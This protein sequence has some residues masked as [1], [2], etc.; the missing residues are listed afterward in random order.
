MNFFQ[1]ITNFE[2]CNSEWWSFTLLPVIVTTAVSIIYFFSFHNFSDALLIM[3]KQLLSYSI[4]LTTTDLSLKYKA[5]KNKKSQIGSS[6]ILLILSAFTLVYF[7]TANFGLEVFYFWIALCC[8]L[9]SMIFGYWSV[10]LYN[11]NPDS[12]DSSPGIITKAKED[13]EKKSEKLFKSS[14]VKI[15]NN[16]KWG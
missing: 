11:H 6:V 12:F 14:K 8:L 4:I 15:R 5:K 9:V 3:A 13:Y 16:V 7:Y 2:H 10:Y 1:K